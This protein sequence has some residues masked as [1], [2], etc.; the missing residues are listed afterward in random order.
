MDRKGFTLCGIVITA[1][2]GALVAWSINA[3]NPVLPVVGLTV[4]VLLLYLCKKRV[5][6]VVEDERIYRIGGKAAK[7]ALNVFAIGAVYLGLVLIILE[8]RYSQ[9][10]TA[11]VHAGCTLLILYVAFYGYYSTRVVE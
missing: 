11:L 4:A 8:G 7:A 1:A 5:T 3:G 10:G 2:L 6:E 9:A